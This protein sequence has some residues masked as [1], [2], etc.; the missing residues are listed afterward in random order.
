MNARCARQS[1]AKLP[2]C[3]MMKVTSG[4]S[5]ATRSTTETSPIGS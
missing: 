4:Y 2:R 1:S 3:G 5:S